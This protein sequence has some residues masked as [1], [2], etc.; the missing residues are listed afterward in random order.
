[1]NSRQRKKRRNV[2][3]AVILLSGISSSGILYLTAGEISPSPLESFEQ[4][5]R[6]ANEVERMGGKVSVFAN[7]L[8]KWFSSLWQGEMLAF[9]IAGFTLFIAAVYYLLAS[10]LDSEAELRE[11]LPAGPSETGIT[12]L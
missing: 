12:E 10:A 11:N 7:G 2:T 5:K 4:S 3:T 9:T 8:S 6:F 1:M